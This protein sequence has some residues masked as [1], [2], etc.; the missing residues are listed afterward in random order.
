MARTARVSNSNRIPPATT[1]GG[2]MS[3]RA[4]TPVLIALSM[5]GVVAVAALALLVARLLDRETFTDTQ[6]VTETV[7][8]L[9]ADIEPGILS[10]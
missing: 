10:S 3:S 2:Q 7:S 1:E 4:R 6:V 8:Q 5:V 9:D